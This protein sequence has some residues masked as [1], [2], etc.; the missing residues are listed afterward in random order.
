V[1][2]DFGAEMRGLLAF[3]VMALFPGLAVV[4][5]P[6]TAVPFLS[7]SF[8]LLSA[9]WVPASV[10]RSAF[11][12]AA[13]PFFGALTTLRLLKPL[14]PLRPSRSSLAVLGLALACL[15]PVLA[16]P[17]APGLGLAST[18]ATL[19]YWR[20]GFPVTYE[21]LAPIPA[22]GGHAPGLPLLAADVARLSGL[23]PPRAVLLV[24]FAGAGLLAIAVWSLFRRWGRPRR[25]LAVVALVVAVVLVPMAFPHPPGWRARF[26]MPGTP[27][28]GPIVLAA[29]LGVSALGLLV[30]GSGRAPAVAA[31]FFLGAAFAVEAVTGTA[32]LGLTALRGDRARRRWALALGLVLAMPRLVGLR[33]LSVAEARTGAWEV[34]GSGTARSGLEPAV[35]DANALRAMAW[36]RVA[37]DP[38]AP[39]CAPLGGAAAFVPAVAQRAVVPAEVPLVYRE[40]ASR[41]GERPCRYL[42]WLGPLGRAGMPIAPSPQ[43]FCSSWRVVFED[44]EA[45]VLEA[46][47]LDAPVTSFDKVPGNPVAPRP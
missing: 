13:L 10:S 42:L 17:V 3:L 33:A 44:G 45:R 28:P 5:A 35:P 14:P 36:L 26:G 47:S 46:A 31:G 19:L 41:S 25:G 24:A 8:W 23:P 32:A 11:L 21:P 40:E 27:T 43:S 15:L 1:D 37:T 22:F 20:D 7:L 6:W 12:G 39:V 38:L 29:A 9:W 18:E 2:L 30:R 4:R 16:L 34:V